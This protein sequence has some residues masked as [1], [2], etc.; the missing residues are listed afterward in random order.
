M[1]GEGTAGTK[2]EEQG[3]GNREDGVSQNLPGDRAPA[4][5]VVAPTVAVSKVNNGDDGG[6]DKLT[7]ANNGDNSSE[8]EST[9]V[10]HEAAAHGVCSQALL[11]V[12]CS[13]L[14]LSTSRIVDRDLIRHTP[15]EV[16]AQ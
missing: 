11:L 8:R 16:H 9:Y 13:T 1:A 10:A 3:A 12:Y 5:D 2:D 7:E 6:K 4:V 14:K 15:T